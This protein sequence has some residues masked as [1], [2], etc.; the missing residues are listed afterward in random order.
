MIAVVEDVQSDKTKSGKDI[1]K[2]KLD[3]KVYTTFDRP[4]AEAAFELKGKQAD[5]QVEVKQSGEFTNY[6]L[7]GIKPAVSAKLPDPPAVS[8]SESSRQSSIQKQCALKSAVEFCKSD[9]KATVEGVLLAAA[10]F[11]AWLSGEAAPTNVRDEAD[12]IPF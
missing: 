1:Y 12:D 4:V 10:A 6:N 2:V 7:R 11:D 3:G 8:S 5:A 9:A